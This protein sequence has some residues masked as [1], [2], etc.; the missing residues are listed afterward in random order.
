MPLSCAAPRPSAIWRAIASAS[1]TGSGALL[2]PL[3]ERLAFDQLQH[4]ERLAV[5]LLEAVDRADVRVV[6]RREHLRLALEA[7][8]ALGVV[9]D[10]R[11]STLIA[12]SRDSRVSGA[13]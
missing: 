3:R 2:E 9:R 10:V 5:G 4:Q 1:A 13:R 11:G 6:E 12:T 7:R 8:Q